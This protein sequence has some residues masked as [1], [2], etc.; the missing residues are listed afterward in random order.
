MRAKLLIYSQHSENQTFKRIFKNL[1]IHNKQRRIWHYRFL[2]QHKII[3]RLLV[4]WKHSAPEMQNAKEDLQLDLRQTVVSP[5]T[6]K[7][8]LQESESGVFIFLVPV[9]QPYPLGKHRFFS[10]LAPLKQHL[11]REKGEKGLERTLGSF[12]F[13]LFSFLSL[14]IFPQQICR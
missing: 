4:I 12:F 3:F 1:D 5:Y 14:F 2:W 10:L 8:L 11:G 13:F 7:T 6:N 9:C